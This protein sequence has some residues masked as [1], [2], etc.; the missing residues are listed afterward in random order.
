MKGYV[1]CIFPV[2]VVKSHVHF[3]QLFVSQSYQRGCNKVPSLLLD[4][5]SVLL[6]YIDWSE[7][8]AERWGVGVG[9]GS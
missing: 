5:V 3:C 9:E 1:Q 6:Y 4:I 7:H 8:I 2:F